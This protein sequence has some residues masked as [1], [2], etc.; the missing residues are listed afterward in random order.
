MSGPGEQDRDAVDRAF[1]D[2]VAGWHLTADRPEPDGDLKPTLAPT[3]EPVATT[4]EAQTP[5]ATWADQHPLFRYPDRQPLE[6]EP[7]ER[8]VPEPP[9]AL[10][11]PGW[12]VLLAWLA[13]GY[14]VL[15][16]L[17]AALG[18]RLPAW[19]GW[20]AVIGF[21]GGFAVL[22]TRLP[23]HRSPDAGDGAVL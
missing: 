9:P 14:A 7:E 16:V 18:V 23:R 3:A 1:A 8:F 2:L 12:P 13:M 20:C 4:A 15:A 10:P 5:D 6:Q 11:R 22:L 17:A 19:A 21:I